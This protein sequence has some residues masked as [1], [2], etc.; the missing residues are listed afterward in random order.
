MG[1]F[2]FKIGGGREGALKLKLTKL[3]EIFPEL[4][5]SSLINFEPLL[6][7]S[8]NGHEKYKFLIEVVAYDSSMAPH[9]ILYINLTAFE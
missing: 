5:I 2:G 7:G 4:L 3:I 1:K 6:R 9:D 8:E